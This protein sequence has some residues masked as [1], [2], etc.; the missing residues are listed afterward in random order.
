MAKAVASLT[1]GNEKTGILGKTTAAPAQDNKP[2]ISE[3]ADFQFPV[4]YSARGCGHR[5]SR[6]F[7]L[8]K[9]LTVAA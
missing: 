2:S 7:L 9:K 6:Y 1:Q 3:T 8:A 5:N 4:G